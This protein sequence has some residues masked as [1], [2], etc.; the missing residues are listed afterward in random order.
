MQ[1]KCMAFKRKHKNRYT[2][3]TQSIW[4]HLIKL[5]R[6]PSACEMLNK[7]EQSETIAAFCVA[8]RFFFLC[9]QI[10]FIVSSS[11]Y[12][13][14]ISTAFLEVVMIGC[15]CVCVWFFDPS[16]NRHSYKYLYFNIAKSREIHENQNAHWNSNGFCRVRIS[17]TIS[18][19]S[20][21]TSYHLLHNTFIIII[22]LIALSDIIK[23]HKELPG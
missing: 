5:H 8:L 12:L 11:V 21:A 9:F 19:L 15:A 18:I 1:S 22:S 10:A 14:S 3:H 20:L 17:A 2:H 13:S 6:R 16:A 4:L 23:L 7:G